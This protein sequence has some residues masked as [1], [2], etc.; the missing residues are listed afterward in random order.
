MTTENQEVQVQ[1]V[2]Q[3]VPPKKDKKGGESSALLFTV[4]AL[5]AIQIL[6]YFVMGVPVKVQEQQ[7]EYMGKFAH[8][9]NVEGTF[10]PLGRNGW[11]VAYCR[12]AHDGKTPPNYGYECLFKRLKTP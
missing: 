12:R 5:L 1:S 10:D 3:A 6:V 9:S 11:E 7:W 8:D 2:S 4:I